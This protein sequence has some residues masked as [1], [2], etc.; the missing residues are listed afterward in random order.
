MTVPR[1]AR[2]WLV[3]ALVV[4]GGLVLL[5]A[6][7]REVLGRAG[8]TST[9]LTIR[10][11]L[12]D[13]RIVVFDAAGNAVPN[14]PATPIAVA[15]AGDSP[16]R[17]VT[18][19]VANTGTEPHQFVVLETAYPPNALPIENDRARLYYVPDTPDLGVHYPEGMQFFRDNQTRANWATVQPSATL[20][21][22]V[23]HPAGPAA[24]PLTLLC[25]LPGHYANGE[26]AVVEIRS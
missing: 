23:G 16:Y 14:G 25:N 9:E 26:Y 17:F 15:G 1:P 4:L 12:R 24:R 21:A 11:E 19:E 7:G 13:D 10:V 22:L 5:A 20:T 8:T 2:R 3:P 6:V 18:F